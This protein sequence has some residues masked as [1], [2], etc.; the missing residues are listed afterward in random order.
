MKVLCVDAGYKLRPD[1]SFGN[2]PELI[3]GAIYTVIRDIVT[4]YGTKGYLLEEAKGTHHSLGA[5]RADRFVPLSDIDE[6][7]MARENI[8]SVTV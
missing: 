1:N 4:E 6:R 5:F 3:E 2:A 7:E 8:E